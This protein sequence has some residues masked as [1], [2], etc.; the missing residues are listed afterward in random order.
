M[1]K[2]SILFLLFFSISTVYIAQTDSTVNSLSP[3]VSSLKKNKILK[4]STLGLSLN[5]LGE[6]KDELI[7]WSDKVISININEKTNEFMLIHND[8]MQQAEL[9]EVLKKYNIQKTNIVSYK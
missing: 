5:V 8:L 4:I 6:M 9:F 7:M 2:K 1:K 3:N